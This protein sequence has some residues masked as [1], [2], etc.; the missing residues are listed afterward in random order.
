MGYRSFGVC[1]SGLRMWNRFQRWGYLSFSVVKL[2]FMDAWVFLLVWFTVRNRCISL[3]LGVNRCILVHIEILRRYVCQAFIAQV[4]EV[5]LIR[6]FFEP[7]SV[8]L[9]LTFWLTYWNIP[10]Y[11]PVKKGTYPDSHG[12]FNM[13]KAGRDINLVW[14]PPGFLSCIVCPW[15]VIRWILRCYKALT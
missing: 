4:N 13:G 11:I 10:T 1:R 12:V 15:S 14:L 2:V 7:G 5:D 6:R 3:W 9:H 8:Y